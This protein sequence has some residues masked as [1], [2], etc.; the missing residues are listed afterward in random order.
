MARIG[1]QVPHFEKIEYDS[2][3]AD[4][5]SCN[6]YRYTLNMHYRESAENRDKTVS[7]VLK[8]PSSADE[9]MSDATIRRVETYVYKN[10]P[11]AQ[12]LNILNVFAYRATDAIDVNSLI[13]EKG[14]QHAVGENNDHHIE[15]LCDRSDVIICAWG[16]HS[17]IN[18]KQYDSRIKSVK[19][20]LTS[21]NNK[22]WQ[23]QGRAKHYPQH[24]LYWSYEY[25][26]IRYDLL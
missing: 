3:T 5:S 13:R 24:G 7:V 18:K 11:D 19:S 23:V 15:S 10:I 8:N 21:H 14:L 9:K 12:F 16:S 17:Q 25:P 20:L 26:L 1:R 6:T 4:F 2:I 22:I